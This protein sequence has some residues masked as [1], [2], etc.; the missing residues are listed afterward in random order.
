MTLG[1]RN[2]SKLHPDDGC[3][4]HD[5]PVHHTLGLTVDSM[6]P[7][8]DFQGQD[9]HSASGSHL[10]AEFAFFHAAEADKAL[11]SL[12]FPAVKARE[13]GRRFDHDDPG[14]EGAAR[15]MTGNPELIIAHFLES[16]DSPQ[17]GGRIDDAVEVLHVASLLIAFTDR[18][19]VVNDLLQIDDRDVKQEAWGHVTDRFWV[20]PALLMMSEPCYGPR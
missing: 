9:V 5:R 2:S 4:K 11:P 14:Q 20:N 12:E 15:N 19:L 8:P 3:L 6:M 1:I 13:L 7:L 17:V 18:S 16:D 10:C